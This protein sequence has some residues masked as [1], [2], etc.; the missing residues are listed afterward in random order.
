[1]T[2][3]LLHLRTD[4]T[5]SLYKQNKGVGIRLSEVGIALLEERKHKHPMFAAAPVE[6]STSE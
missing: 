4:S 6:E 5:P 3:E 2:T 1:M